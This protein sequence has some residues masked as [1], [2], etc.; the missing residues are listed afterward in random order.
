[1]KLDK[2]QSSVQLKSI[3][4]AT[5]VEYFL[6]KLFQLLTACPIQIRRK[7]N[8]FYGK[9]TKIMRYWATFIIIL[10]CVYGLIFFTIRTCCIKLKSRLNI[11]GEATNFAGILLTCIAVLIETQLTHHRFSMF[12]TGK[13]KTEDQLQTLC[14]SE[15]FDCEKSNFLHSYYKL[16]VSFLAMTLMF[17]IIYMICIRDDNDR[18]FYCCWVMLPLLFTRL[19]CLQHRFYT[20]TLTF[21]VKFIRM[22]IERNIDEIEFNQLICRQQNLK[23]FPLNSQKLYN[24]L[25]SA[26][27]IYSTVYQMSFHVNKMFGISLLINIIEN[28]VQLL[29]QL[30]WMYSR[31]HQ[32]DF[33]N[34]YG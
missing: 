32:R 14:Q 30:C 27:T 21:Y 3:L 25:C 24:E 8:R 5:N 28:F 22:H 20:S 29:S 11:W 6:L 34:L 15:L 12:L 26:K 9:F 10:I 7:K 13:Q 4:W 16:F 2:Q 18:M 23:S 17:D 31:L 19:R 1:M 33:E